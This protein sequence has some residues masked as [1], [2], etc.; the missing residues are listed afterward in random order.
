MKQFWKIGCLFFMAAMNF[1]CVCLNIAT[2]QS[3]KPITKALVIG[4][5]TYQDS[6]IA[7]LP[8]AVRDAEFFAGFIKS[9]DKNFDTRAELLLLTNKQA[10]LAGLSAGLDWLVEDTQKGDTLLLFF[11]AYSAANEPANGNSL[12]FYDSPAHRNTS[13]SFNLF[14]QFKVLAQK[15]KAI[16]RCYANLYPAVFNKKNEGNPESIPVMP[17]IKKEALFKNIVEI[18]R[19]REKS[20]SQIEMETREAKISLVSY[21]IKGLMGLAD[22]NSDRSVSLKELGNYFNKLAVFP[23]IQPGIL[24]AASASSKDILSFVNSTNLNAIEDLEY[25]VLSPLVS[26]ETNKKELLEIQQLSERNR[27]MYEDFLLSISLGHLLNDPAKNASTILDTLTKEPEMQKLMTNMRRKLAAALQDESQQVLNAYLNVDAKELNNRLRGNVSYDIYAQ[28]LDKAIQLLGGPHYMTKIL[29][30]KKLYFEAV[31]K[32]I[33]GQKNFNKDLISESIQLLLVALAL[34][35][36]ASFLHNELGINYSLFGRREEAKKSFHSAIEFSPTWSIPFTNLAQL[37]AQEDLSKALRIAKHA[38]R[39]SPHNS[40]AWNVEGSLNMQ[41][42][43]YPAAEA[44]FIK[45]LK[46]DPN[47]AV[48]CYNLACALSLQKKTEDAYDKLEQAIQAGITNFEEISKDSDFEN[49][50]IFSI[51]WND[52]MEKYFLEK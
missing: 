3:R 32:R 41:L 5:S 38:V 50:K 33:T 10:S 14:A 40:F 18:N 36:Q 49:L 35:N 2:A 48:A 47:Y 42:R 28:Y 17:E 21:L 39:L 22:D 19:I 46:L 1:Y 27:I 34:E 15:K 30:A 26:L 6:T 8:F 45:A 52:L 7:I 16:Y 51:R 20:E 12:Y 25:S 31:Q 37:Y 44:S 23:W 4:I 11:A 13:T 9:F 29:K 43:N 24:F